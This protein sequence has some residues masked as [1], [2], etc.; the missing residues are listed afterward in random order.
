MTALAEAQVRLPPPRLPPLRRYKRTQCSAPWMLLLA[1]ALTLWS[2]RNWVELP[3]FS[4]WEQIHR[5][6]PGP[7]KLEG[8]INVR[9]SRYLHSRKLAYLQLFTAQSATYP[10]VVAYTMEYTKRY[11]IHHL[12]ESVLP[13]V[14]FPFPRKSRFPSF[15]TKYP[16]L[17]WKVGKTSMSEV[18]MYGNAFGPIFERELFE[19][20]A[21]GIEL[22]ELR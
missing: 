17:P 9:F 7:N 4:H 21:W 12:L 14:V 20:F 13:L 19:A 8:D 2:R 6:R 5:R 18:E 11:H 1:I 3:S 15:W 10:Y 16:I 22:M